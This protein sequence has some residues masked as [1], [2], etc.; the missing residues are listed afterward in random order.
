MASLGRSSAT[1]TSHGHTNGVAETHEKGTK[2]RDK[3][4]IFRFFADDCPYGDAD[5]ISVTVMCLVG[6]GNI[7]KVHFKNLRANPRVSLK[8]VVDVDVKAAE[9]FAAKVANCTPLAA[10][11]KALAVMRGFDCIS[12]MV[13][14]RIP[15]SRLWSLPPPLLFTRI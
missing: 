5:G 13:S 9:A 8:Y 6:T 7:G 14:H 4:R 11:D 15:K 3:V 12:D 1:M 2:R 10:L